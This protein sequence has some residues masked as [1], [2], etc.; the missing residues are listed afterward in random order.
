[1]L[2]KEYGAAIIDP[3]WNIDQKGKNSNRS[4]ESRYPLMTL[5]QIKAM[6]IGDLMKP[7]SFVFL[8]FTPGTLHYVDSV[9]ETWG[10]R[11]VSIMIW[12]KEAGGR[13]GLGNVVRHNAEFIRIGVRGHATV[14]FHGQPSVFYAPA[15]EHSHKP[16]ETH[17]IVRRL[18]GDEM[19][20]CCEIFARRPYPGWDVWGNEVPSDFKIEGYPVPRYSF[21]PGFYDPSADPNKE[22]A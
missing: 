21:D 5:K 22:G 2:K 6:P 14:K 17:Q 11:P 4:A 3:P 16:E 15:Q 8:W 12:V 20:P 1:M 9:L 13:L 19:G 18:V 7:D 10:Y